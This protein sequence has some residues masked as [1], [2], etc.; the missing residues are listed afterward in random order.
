M[1][2]ILLPDGDDPHSVRVFTQ[3]GN[4]FA[5]ASDL[6]S[7][8]PVSGVADVAVWFLRVVD[9]GNHTAIGSSD[10]AL[11]NKNNH[12]KGGAALAQPILQFYV[13]QTSLI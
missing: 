1:V 13:V 9:E 7:V 2:D 12:D 5:L 6:G 11:A 8:A 3:F 10:S 4:A